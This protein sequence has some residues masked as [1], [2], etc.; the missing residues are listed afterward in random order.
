MY[1][2]LTQVAR[3]AVMKLLIN[4]MKPAVLN[5]A[6]FFAQFN[7]PPQVVRKHQKD[8]LKAIAAKDPDGA[9]KAADAYLKKG[10]ET[11][12]TLAAANKS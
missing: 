3:N 1:V 11:A 2:I 5:Y 7:A 8:L 4:T 12:H 10:V 9:M 6:P